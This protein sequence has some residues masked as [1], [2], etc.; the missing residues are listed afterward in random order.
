M[1]SFLPLLAA[2]ALGL[3]LACSS[4]SVNYDYNAQT[5]FSAYRSYAWQV[6]PQGRPGP[7]DNAIVL[8]RVQHA[9]EVELGAKGFGLQRGGDNPDFLVNYYPVREASRSHQVHLGLGFGFGPLGV[10]VAAPV[11][12]PN[13]EAVSGIVL[14][15]RDFRSGSV[16]WTATAEGALQGSDNPE[17]ADSDVKDAVHT[18]LKRFPP[19]GR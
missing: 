7:F 5:Q 4:P 3:G 6:V 8:A 9:V 19:P 12:D 18:M 2:G 11:G 14:E 16:V 1:R 13:R 10:G 17:E 15:V